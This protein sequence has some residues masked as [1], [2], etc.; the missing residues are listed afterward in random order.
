LRAE[1]IDLP[2]VELGDVSEIQQADPITLIAF[3]P[4]VNLS[5]FLTGVVSVKSD[6]VIVVN[7]KTY[8]LRIVVFQI[9]VRGGVSGSP[10]FSNATGHVIGVVTTKV[11]GI[12][13]QLDETL[14]KLNSVRELTMVSST[15]AAVGIIVIS[16]PR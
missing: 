12:S 16:V 6:D 7:K 13:Q 4:T 15:G 14:S 10:I 9:P 2:Y 1:V 8:Q 11:Y 5:L 3:V